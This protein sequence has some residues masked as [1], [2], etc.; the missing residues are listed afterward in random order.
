MMRV[1]CGFVKRM[2]PG[3]ARSRARRL[4]SDES[5]HCD[6]LIALGEWVVKTRAAGPNLQ[7]GMRG[8]DFGQIEE[9]LKDPGFKI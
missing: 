7:S 9:C 3:S 8:E 6:L 2:V 1:R 5:Y 4:F